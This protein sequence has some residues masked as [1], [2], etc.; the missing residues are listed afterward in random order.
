ML[1]FVSLSKN[2]LNGFQIARAMNRI[3]FEAA[4]LRPPWSMR[5]LAPRVTVGVG[6]VKNA[7][8]VGAGLNEARHAF[9]IAEQWFSVQQFPGEFLDISGVSASLRSEFRDARLFPYPKPEA[10]AGG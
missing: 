7:G 3:R 10:A 5:G 2:V 8:I 6:E 4:R 9:S 1:S